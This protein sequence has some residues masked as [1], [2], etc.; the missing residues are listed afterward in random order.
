VI[1]PS[2]AAWRRTIRS[3]TSRS[4]AL[5]AVA[6]RVHDLEGELSLL[7]LT[8]VG[9]IPSHAVRGAAYRRAGITLPRTSSLHWKARFF[10]PSGLVVGEHTTLGNDGF[11]DAREGITIGD[12]VNIAAEV[13]IF[14]R[15]HDVQSP[16]FAETG[17]PVRIGNHAYLAT[18][19]TVLPG[20]TIG[21]GAVVASGSVVT[22]DV[23]PF[24]IVGGV[25]AR[26]IGER[27]RDLR[28]TLGYAKRFQ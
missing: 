6:A 21:E 1:P 15:E 28:Y 18:R 9:S 11:Y 17:G 19:V 25:P 12:S 23:E 22:K 27:R 5:G 10:V 20:V 7:L 24:Q 26:P 8:W 2:V 16:D 13:R 14:T 4:D 3:V